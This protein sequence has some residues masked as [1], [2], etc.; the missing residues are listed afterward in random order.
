MLHVS[1]SFGRKLVEELQH[2]PTF[3]VHAAKIWPSPLK[4]RTLSCTRNGFMSL[5]RPA[6]CIR[7]YWNLR[8]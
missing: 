5:A 8:K 4:D 3:V 1:G 6:L 7:G 2:S